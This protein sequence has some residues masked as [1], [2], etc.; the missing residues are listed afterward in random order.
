[1]ESET[2]QCV[3]VALK[4]NVLW[5]HVILIFVFVWYV[6]LYERLGDW[7]KYACDLYAVPEYARVHKF[8][9]TL[10]EQSF[11]LKIHRRESVINLIVL[12]YSLT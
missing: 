10:P 12:F 8:A 1:M 7:L 11:F 4:S 2:A 5:C 3:A 6:G 9:P